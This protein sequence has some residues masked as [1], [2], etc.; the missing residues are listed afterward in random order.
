VDRN[1]SPYIDEA[2]NL[3]F[4]PQVTLARAVLQDRHLYKFRSI[5]DLVQ[6]ERLKDIVLGHRIRFSRP[7]ELN[8]LLEGKPVYVLGDWSSGDYRRRFAAWAWRGQQALVNPP[9]RD[10][11]LAWVLA[12]PKEVHEER[13]SAINREN[14]ANIESKWRVLSLSANSTHDLMWS[15]YADGHRGV[16]LVFDASRGDLSLAFR[17]SYE[18]GKTTLD[19]TFP[20]EA[21][22]LTATLLRKRDTW[23][24]ERE[25]RCI[26]TE[27]LIP[28]T[29]R[30]DRQFLS[31]NPSQL[32]GVVFGVNVKREHEVEIRSWSAQR[33]V[34][35][36]FWK[37]H[38]GSFGAV[39]IVPSAS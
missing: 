13:I 35:L 2:L 21:A 1:L 3:M 12:Q 39:E 31:L 11:F 17:V 38:I 25:F 10:N 27:A 18:S 14:Q 34:P 22:V 32:V 36:A 19:I 30:L 33:S 26:G 29:I 4:A 28:N 7:S 9:D 24:Y 20:D 16:A 8:D 15:H 23:K 37:A 5:T 6:L